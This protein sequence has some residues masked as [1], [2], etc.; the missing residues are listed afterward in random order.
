MSGMEHERFEEL[1]EA[2]VLGALTEEERREF[3][4]YLARHPEKQAEIEELGA[5]AG[6]LALSPP[7]QEPSPELRRRVLARV[8][9]EATSG[10]EARNALKDRLGWIL[11]PRTLAAAGAALAVAG[12]LVW[13]GLLQRELGNLRSENH[14]LQGQV[15]NLKAYAMR[16]SGPAK[17]ASAEVLRMRNGKMILTASNLPPAP[18][19]KTY[20]IWVIENGTPKPAG[21]FTPSGKAVAVPVQV[22]AKKAQAV[23]VTIEPAGGSKR[24]TSS[25]ILVSHLSAQSNV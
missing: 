21:L 17:G 8:R 12:L 7:E 25:P 13:N 6:L 22:R 10:G 15:E 19:G 11:R 3:E 14:N 1:K 5:I 23:A 9:S 18:D 4:S 16:S 20:Q 24:P 2:Y